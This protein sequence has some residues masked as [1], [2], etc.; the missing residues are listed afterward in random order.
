MRSNRIFNILFFSSNY[1]RIFIFDTHLR[2]V[3]GLVL[4]CR[5]MANGILL[6]DGKIDY[7]LD[8]SQ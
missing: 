4:L 1:D 3:T 2:M 6:R 7:I 5:S 8:F